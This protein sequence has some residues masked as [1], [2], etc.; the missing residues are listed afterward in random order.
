MALAQIDAEYLIFDAMLAVQ[1]LSWASRL[2]SLVIDLVELDRDLTEFYYLL[3]TFKGLVYNCYVSNNTPDKAI[4]AFNKLAP[5][6]E[7]IQEK[8]KIHEKKFRNFSIAQRQLNDLWK[9][10][11][12]FNIT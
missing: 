10:K 2:P 5:K 7:S 1:E 8:L 9:F 4:V 3:D 12:H 11:E 6:L